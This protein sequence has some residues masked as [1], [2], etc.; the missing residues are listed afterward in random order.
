[1]KCI[2]ITHLLILNTLSLL[3][4]NV[5]IGNTTPGF[6][7]NFAYSFGDKISLYG[8]SGS[9]YGIGVQS[10]LLQ[11]HTDAANTNIAFG[12]GSSSSFTERALIKN[13]GADGMILNG[14]LLLKNGTFPVDINE[15]PG[16]WLY[17]A[18]NSSQFCFVGT[19]NNQN[20]GFYDGVKG[21]WFIYDAVN[22]R[23][24]I[25]TNTPVLH[26]M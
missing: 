5:G 14:R 9:H 20:I 12:Y 24:G 18:D 2:L 6:P 11:L 16:V 3:S 4:Q 10:G 22:S 17:K 26:L 15:P 19:Q 1:M 23:V 25:G 7:L 13:G 21:W 8:N